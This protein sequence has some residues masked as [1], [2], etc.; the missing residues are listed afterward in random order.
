MTLAHLRMGLN[1]SAHYHKGPSF[2]GIAALL[3]F[4]APD[5]YPL[6]LSL[7]QP[8]DSIAINSSITIKE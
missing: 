6:H 5:H 2:V 7:N 4:A 8:K 1:V 3:A